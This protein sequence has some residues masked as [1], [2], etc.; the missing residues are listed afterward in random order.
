MAG[1]RPR[2]LEDFLSTLSFPRDEV[3]SMLSFL[4]DEG[5]IEHL[6]DDTYATVKR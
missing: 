3:I 6:E 2:R 4:V 5:F 1:L